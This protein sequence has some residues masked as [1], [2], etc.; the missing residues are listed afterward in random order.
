MSQSVRDFVA[1][2]E[3]SSPS[4]VV[5]VT[6]PVSLEYEVMALVLEYER[7]RQFPIL[8]LEH[9][10]GSE[11]PIVCNVVASRRALAF[12]LGVPESALAVEYARRIKDT[13]KPVVV[14]DA[15]FR[16]ACVT[17]RELDLA[18]LPIPT[19][20]PGDAGDLTMG[21]SRGGP[22]TPVETEGYHCFSKGPDRLGVSPHSARMLE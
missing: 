20:F 8:L 6:E 18:R 16:H 17:G 4:E 13:I 3:K 11:M 12:A 22:E 5:R 21:I 7:R 14:G 1:A 19:Y 9:V 2:Y 10:R 15:P